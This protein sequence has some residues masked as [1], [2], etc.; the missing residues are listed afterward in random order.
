MKWQP[1]ETA[2]KDGSIILVYTKRSLNYEGEG[3]GGIQEAYYD[4]CNSQW[5]GWIGGIAVYPMH[6]CE[7]EL[8]KEE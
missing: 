1:I 6:W 2:P 8:P 3:R 4:I 7:I 5:W